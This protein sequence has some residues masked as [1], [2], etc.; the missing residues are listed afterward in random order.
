VGPLRTVFGKAYLLPFDGI[1]FLPFDG[2]YFGG[3]LEKKAAGK[4]LR[5]RK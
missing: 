4:S 3:R 2:I 1:Y 5:L